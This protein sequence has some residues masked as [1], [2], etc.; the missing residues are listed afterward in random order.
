MIKSSARRRHTC[1]PARRGPLLPTLLPT[2]PPHSPASLLPPGAGPRHPDRL[3]GVCRRPRPRVSTAPVPCSA[4]HLPVTTPASVCPSFWRPHKHLETLVLELRGL[5]S[6][7]AS[8]PPPRPAPLPCW[9]SSH[10]SGLGSPHPRLGAPGRGWAGVTLLK[11]RKH[12]NTCVP[13]LPACCTQCP[14]SRP[15]ASPPLLRTLDGLVSARPTCLRDG[16]AWYLP[17]LP[18]D[19]SKEECSLEGPGG[20]SLGILET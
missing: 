4:A 11:G 18:P 12:G 10:S 16:A 5:H 3:R 8:D 17:S 13:W 1:P 19:T 14:P 20:A 7:R 9:E 2:P 6:P 15:R